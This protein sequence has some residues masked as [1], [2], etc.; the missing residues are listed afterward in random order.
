MIAILRRTFDKK[1]FVALSSIILL[2]LGRSSAVWWLSP[3]TAVAGLF[4]A[5]I[6]CQ[7]TKLW[8]SWALFWIVLLIQSSWLLSHPY[9]YIWGVWIVLS[10]LFSLPY[11]LLARL[12]IQETKRGP[13]T[14]AGWAAAFSLLEWSFTLLPCGY[15]FQSA[16][17]QLSWNLWSLQLVSIV[18][19]VG[20]GFLVF[21]TNI[22]LFFWFTSKRPSLAL[23]TFCIALAPYLLGGSLFY[24]K[25]QA[26]RA[27]DTT[28]PPPTVAFCHM[29][30]PPDVESRALPPHLLYE[31]EWKKI[32]RLMARLHP[33]EVDL[34][35]LPE[36]AIPFAAESP[37]FRSSQLPSS[38][39]TSS[40]LPG[41]LSSIDIAR[42]T[43]SWLH[44]SVL[45]G[46]EG[47]QIE[48]DGRVAAYNSCYVVTKETV[49]RY[50]KQLL[51]PLGEYIPFPALASFLSSYGIHGSF[52]PGKGSAL[53]EAGSLRISPLI[54][55]EETF[56]SYALAASRLHPTLLVNLTNDCWYPTVRR[57]HFELARLRAVEVGIP[58]VRSCNQGVSAAIDAL[59]RVVA[60]RG[61]RDDCGNACVIT[62]LS[63]YCA[64]SLYASMGQT[65][66]VLFLAA[67]WAGVIVLPRFAPRSKQV[68]EA[69]LR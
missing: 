62:P 21:W 50:D 2:G 8:F 28:T 18:G 42:M 45:I 44:T 49:R 24:T 61:E 64:P 58:L 39:R 69:V 20:L 16:A 54:C 38:L 10:L 14:A 41:Q 68:K 27:F 35:V 13:F 12:V 67:L 19:A 3:L 25:T 15:S 46:L 36:G 23:T 34:I 51:L 17:L 29:E 6:A 59:G 65:P 22:L 47:R 5:L 26:Q 57:E 37:L 30:E 4:C 66:I 55:Y 43:A 56:S 40:P 11:A 33:N 48:Q 32:F 53:F 52:S 1:N 7:R 60:A 63:Q 31:Q 9:V